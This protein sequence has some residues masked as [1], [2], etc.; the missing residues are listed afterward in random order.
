MF[1]PLEQWP[2]ERF[3]IEYTNPLPRLSQRLL[4]PTPG[5]LF[6]FTRSTDK[7]PWESE[8]DYYKRGLI[9]EQKRALIYGV[10]GHDVQ[11]FILEEEAAAFEDVRRKRLQRLEN[12]DVCGG[13]GSNDLALPED[14]VF[15][16]DQLPHSD[17]SRKIILLNRGNWQDE[18]TSQMR[19]DVFVSASAQNIAGDLIFFMALNNGNFRYNLTHEWSHFLQKPTS[20]FDAPNRHPEEWSAFMCAVDIEWRIW[21]PP[22]STYAL[23]AYNEHWAVIGQNFL[24]WVGRYASDVITNAPLRTFFWSRAFALELRDI[25]VHRRPVCFNHL[26]AR[27]LFSERTV[28]KFARLELD[29]IKNGRGQVFEAHQ[30]AGTIDHLLAMVKEVEGYLETELEHSFMES[31]FSQEFATILGA[32]SLECGSPPKTLDSDL[33]RAA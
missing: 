3:D 7:G 29:D 17:Y 4:G 22:D 16:L 6:I 12:G 20:A 11:I 32:T 28:R 23:K 25:P 18:W 9:F 27:A 30:K 21:M 24:H 13:L 14:V 2:A 19:G 26:L 31:M 1:T 10:E 8:S 33:G 5:T 15:N